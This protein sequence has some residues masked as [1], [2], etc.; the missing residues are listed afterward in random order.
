MAVNSLSMRYFI[1][2]PAVNLR[3]HWFTMINIM[4]SIFKVFPAPGPSVQSWSLFDLSLWLAQLSFEAEGTNVS[5]K[6]AAGIFGTVVLSWTPA[7]SPQK[8][9]LVWVL[10]RNS[11]NDLCFFSPAF[12]TPETSLFVE[13]FSGLILLLLQLSMDSI[14]FFASC[15]WWLVFCPR[16]AWLDLFAVSDWAVLW[17][18]TGFYKS[19]PSHSPV[20]TM[21][22]SSCQPAP[23][24]SSLCLP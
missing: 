20:L 22:L 6:A 10:C 24:V 12:A 21:Q 13:I 11:R 8:L 2:T 4:I 1:V 15:T 3:F 23:L 14:G 7:F 18:D 5:W 9:G 16:R 19:F 17:A